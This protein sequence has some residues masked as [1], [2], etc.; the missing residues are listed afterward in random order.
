MLPFILPLAAGSLLCTEFHTINCIIHSSKSFN[1]NHAKKNHIVDPICSSK[2]K[3]CQF[4]AG[5]IPS[6]SVLREQYATKALEIRW[7]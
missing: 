7:Y 5:Y 3:A 1:K 2:K 4:T 6:V